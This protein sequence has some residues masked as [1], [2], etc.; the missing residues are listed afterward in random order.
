MVDGC[1]RKGYDAV[2]YDNLD[3]WTR[4]NGTPLAKKV[5]F[6]KREAVKFA[7][8]LTARAHAEN[9]AVAQKN[10]LNLK[11]ADVRR[12]GFDFA[13][14]EECARYHECG[15]YRR[16]YGDHVIAIEYRR[17]TFGK[18]CRSLGDEFS[19]VLR[20]LQVSRPG[21]PRLPLRLLLRTVARPRELPSIDPELG[22][23][24][25]ARP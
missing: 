3:S 19:I 24:G 5:P 13:I 16:L 4:F 1:A 20:D 6:G 23:S 25:L 21:R 22:P 11:R 9:L 14:A 2:E 18:A 15:G 8:I 10:T 7:R 12:I 17:S